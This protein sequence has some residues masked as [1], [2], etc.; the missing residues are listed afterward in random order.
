MRTLVLC[1][2]LLVLITDAKA[3]PP[4]PTESAIARYEK[5]LARNPSGLA[6]EVRLA[7]WCEQRG[8][9]DRAQE[10]CLRTLFFDAQNKRA[11][12]SLQLSILFEPSENEPDIL[13]K[14]RQA[15]GRLTSRNSPASNFVLAW[16]SL[17]SADETVRDASRAELSA[18]PLR[19]YVPILLSSLS[20][21][22]E[23]GI[24]SQVLGNRVFNHYSFEQERPNGT[25]AQSS[26]SLAKGIPQSKLLRSF[27]KTVAG[28]GKFVPET[29]SCSAGTI[30]AHWE[31]TTTGVHAQYGENP[32]FVAQ[33]NRAR[34]LAGQDKALARAQLNHLNQTIRQR[35]EHVFAL[36]RQT[37]GAE[38]GANPKKWWQWWQERYESDLV[39]TQPTN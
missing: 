6:A 11:L 8:L 33:V 32:Q 34:Q 31:T 15:L 28:T 24:S 4:T 22:V 19:D 2:A 36:L 7:K 29:T 37:T 9:D 12:Q 20:L 26:F 21:P 35:N 3:A 18:K 25:V 23:M 27:H 14:Q 10:H 1:T 13:Q 5:L 38:L 39:N 16:H 17:Y 30:P